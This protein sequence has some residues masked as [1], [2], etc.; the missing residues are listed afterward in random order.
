M[1]I[2]LCVMWLIDTLNYSGGQKGHS[3]AINNVLKQIT[4]NPTL[5]YKPIYETGLSSS[6]LF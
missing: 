3:T 4:S 5:N 1:N 6:T 2:V